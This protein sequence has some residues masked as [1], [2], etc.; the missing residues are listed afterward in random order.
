MKRYKRIIALLAVLAVACVA[1]F[2]VSRYEA[3]KEEIQNSDEVILEIDPD[4]VTALSWSYDDTSLSFHK[5]ETWQYDGDAAFPVDA[6]KIAGLLDQFSQFGVSFIIENVEDY[7]QYGLDDPT[8]TI[9]L[10]AGDTSYTIKLGDFSQM[11]EERYVDIGD[12]NVYL[13]SDDPMD[14]FEVEL[15]DLIDDDELPDFEQV[16]HITFA[17]AQSYTVTREED[18]GKSYSAEDVYF[19][20]DG[21]PLDTARVNSYLSNI[22]SLSTDEYVTYNATDEELEQ[23]GMNDPELTVTVDYSREN[24]DGETVSDTFVLNIARAPG[25]RATLETADSDDADSSDSTASD[26][27]DSI[28]AYLRVG[29][30]QIIYKLD[31]ADFTALMEASYDDLRHQ[32]VFWGDFAD[33]TQLD[34]ELEGTTH[35]I[36]STGSGEDRVYSYNDAE[37]DLS[38]IQTA[39]ESL[40]ADSFTT[41]AASGQEEIA[42]TLHLDNEDFPTVTIRL[43][44]YDGSLCLAE[45]DG[46]SVCLVSRSAAM[47]LVEAVQAIVLN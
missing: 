34:I 47:N 43:T 26:A 45:V 46:E 10:T 44:R 23:Y 15:S 42:L 4:A 37:I 39:V 6:D 24:E 13:V 27:A 7:A 31:G 14:K 28:E 22:S 20:Q 17:G 9:D 12:G 29:E 38:G 16:S 25:D 2:A 8:C 19:N 5:D 1:T 18:S 32:E 35:T 40:T 3:H 33:V 21:Q 11:D 41:E 36:T 30:S